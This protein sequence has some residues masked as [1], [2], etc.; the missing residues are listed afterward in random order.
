MKNVAIPPPLSSSSWR[1]QTL[2][3]LEGLAI[4]KSVCSDRKNCYLD[5]WRDSLTG[6]RQHGENNMNQ[7][8][9]TQTEKLLY[10]A[11]ISSQSEKNK[12]TYNHRSQSVL[13]SELRKY[14]LC[15]C[16]PQ[17]FTQK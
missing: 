15:D 16:A 9:E 10:R 7:L 6:E 11:Y 4:I 5:V 14:W 8:F 17:A 2:N 12:N 13:R 3:Q 1:I